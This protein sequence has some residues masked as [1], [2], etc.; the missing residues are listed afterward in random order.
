LTK[1]LPGGP[2]SLSIPIENSVLCLKC[3]GGKRLCGRATCPHLERIN[4]FARPIPLEKSSFLGSSP[5]SVFVGRYGYPKVR[6]GPLLPPTRVFRPER[7]DDTN[8]WLDREIEDIIAM[9]SSMYR[10]SQ[11]V[12][13]GGSYEPRSRFLS[14]TQEL[15]LSA[16]SVDTEVHLTSV[17]KMERITSFDSRTAPMGPSVAAKKVDIAEN[18]KVPKKVDYLTSDIH[19]KAVEGIEELYLAGISVNHIM[20]ILSAGLL[21]R[22][23]SRRLVPTRWSI[24]AVDDIIGKRLIERV[25]GFQQLNDIQHFTFEHF[26]NHFHVILIPDPYSFEMI[27]TWLKG[28]FWSNDNTLISDHEGYQGRKDYADS[29][30]GAYYAARLEILAH[31]VRIG[32]QSSILVFREITDKYW[33][34]LGV[35]VIR[36]GIREAMKCKP[37]TFPSIDDAVNHVTKSVLVKSWSK[38]SKMLRDM[39]IQR[40]LDEYY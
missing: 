19:A 2:E 12:K 16:K 38:K 37:G 6:V 39:R 15:A 17:P 18:P 34:P 35:W 25:K 8:F 20:R 29:I 32:R 11:E 28:A 31:L 5:P 27:E 23:R 26:G 3:K 13:V 21:G 30:T 10:T 33:A 9:R 14:S 22:A 24:T 4:T 36:E 40:K 1:V 7:L